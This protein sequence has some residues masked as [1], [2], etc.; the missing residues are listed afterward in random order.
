MPLDERQRRHAELFE[1]VEQQ[2]LP[3]WRQ[4][5]LAALAKNQLAASAGEDSPEHESTSSTSS[6]G[7]RAESGARG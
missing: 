3:W 1:N 5:Y 7:H 4:N 2:D 6:S